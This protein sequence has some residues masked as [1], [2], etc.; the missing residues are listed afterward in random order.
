MSYNMSYNI[1]NKNIL[2][3]YGYSIVNFVVG[4]LVLR[5]DVQHQLKGLP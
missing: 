4:C 5:S 2:V 1:Y 3:I